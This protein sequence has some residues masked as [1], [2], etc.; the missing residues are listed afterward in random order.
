MNNNMAIKFLTM[1]RPNTEIIMVKAPRRKVTT[2]YYLLKN[3]EKIV[4]EEYPYQSV[5][6]VGHFLILT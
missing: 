3:S 1:I 4:A 5:V 2:G 6:M